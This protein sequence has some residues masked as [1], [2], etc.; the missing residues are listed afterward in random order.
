VPLELEVDQFIN[1]ESGSSVSFAG[2]T[3][4]MFG[5]FSSVQEAVDAEGAEILVDDPSVMLS[6]ADAALI[7]N[8]ATVLTIDGEQYQAHRRTPATNGLVTLYLTR[9]F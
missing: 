5:I 1:A 2:Q 8:N 7:V 3:A 6:A 4:P 9:D